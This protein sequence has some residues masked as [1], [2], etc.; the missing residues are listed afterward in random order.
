MGLLLAPVIVKERPES[1]RPERSVILLMGVSWS[2]SIGCVAGGL[3]CWGAT[4]VPLREARLREV[5]ED[6][7]GGGRGLGGLRG[8]LL[9]LLS[10]GDGRGGRGLGIPF[11]S[12]GCGRRLKSVCCDLRLSSRFV[13]GRN[14]SSVD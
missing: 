14:A 5:A 11:S 7:G 4:E 12:I 10:I 8:A 13:G 3:G 1:R 2:M 9:P 6:P